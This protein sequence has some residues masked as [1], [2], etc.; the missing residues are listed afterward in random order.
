MFFCKEVFGFSV[1][2]LN[3]LIKNFLVKKYLDF[4]CGKER[5]WS[6]KDFFLC[7]R[8]R[9]ASMLLP[10]KFNDGRRRV[11]RLL[12]CA[13]ALCLLIA[14]WVVFEVWVIENLA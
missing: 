14:F 2:G 1:L 10:F 4:F 9:T 8:S 13:G 3:P 7:G 12:C 11:V 6:C 5:S